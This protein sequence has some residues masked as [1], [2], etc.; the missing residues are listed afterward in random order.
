M[1]CTLRELKT[2]L[3]H[4]PPIIKQK[5]NSLVKAHSGANVRLTANEV[6]NLL[7]ANENIKRVLQGGGKFNYKQ[8]LVLGATLLNIKEQSIKWGSTFQKNERSTGEG[9]ATKF[10]NYSVAI[11]GPEPR[12]PEPRGPEPSGPKPKRLVSDIK[13]V[14]T[15]DRQFRIVAQQIGDTIHVS[16]S[17]FKGKDN[18]C[19]RA[20]SC[21]GNFGV[22]RN[23]MPQFSGDKRLLDPILTDIIKTKHHDAKTSL[24]G[25][26]IYADNADIDLANVYGIQADALAKKVDAISR[27]LQT[28]SM[29]PS[30]FIKDSKFAATNFAGLVKALTSYNPFVV[31]KHG[32]DSYVLDGHHRLYAIQNYNK[33]AREHPEKFKGGPITKIKG[34]YYDITGLDLAE[35]INAIIA[36]APTYNLFDED[37]KPSCASII[38]DA[39]CFS[40]I[41]KEDLDAKMFQVAMQKEIPQ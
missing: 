3:I 27:S 35:I 31:L 9:N 7:I 26:Q 2:R 1:A 25:K 5:F 38:S 39:R 12:G 19:E 24:S 8:L 22:A 34:N 32:K 17:K 4:A 13:T 23:F 21:T 28:R 30:K 10:T 18:F 36:H 29:D 16:T 6:Q 41:P 15:Y 11:N 20:E 14:K 40:S 33:M 37:S